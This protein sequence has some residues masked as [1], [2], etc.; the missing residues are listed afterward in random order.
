MT[1]EASN[2]EEAVGTVVGSKGNSVIV[3]LP[4]GGEILCRSV[5]RLHRPL[6][7]MRVPVGRNARIRFHPTTRERMPL[8][9]EVIRQEP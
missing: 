8:I 7:F 2:P 4:S 1:G 6:G 3:R 5:R 9:V